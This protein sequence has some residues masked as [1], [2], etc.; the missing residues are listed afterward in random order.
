MLQ[1]VILQHTGQSTSASVFG[2][3]DVKGAA[4]NASKAIARMTGLVDNRG[5][6]IQSLGKIQRAVSKLITPG[7]HF[8]YLLLFVIINY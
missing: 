8:Y 4:L 3:D 5:D 2:A 7:I 1:P 6:H